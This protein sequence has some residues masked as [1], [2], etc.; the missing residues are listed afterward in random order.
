QSSNDLLGG[1]KFPERQFRVLVNI[2]SQRDGFTQDFLNRMRDPG[3]ARIVSDGLLIRMNKFR[4]CI[5][6]STSSSPC[7]L[8]DSTACLTDCACLVVVTNR[9]SGVST[10]TISST[11]INAITREVSVTTTPLAASEYTRGVS[12][13]TVTPESSA[14]GFS[15]AIAAKSPTSSQV[16][17]PGI[18]ATSPALAAGSATA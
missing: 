14:A 16:K 18:T 10:T 4:W 9:A 15:R 17:S 11:P 13:I 5:T 6:H 1:P 3:Q 7:A 12:P 2:A 8:M